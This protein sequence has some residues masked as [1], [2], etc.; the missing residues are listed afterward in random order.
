MSPYLQAAIRD[1]DVIFGLNIRFGESTTEGWRLMEVP[2]PAQTL[3]HSHISDLEL[4]KIYQADAP[5]H[6]GPNTLMADLAAREP[7]G[8]WQDWRQK[9]RDGFTGMRA[10][11]TQTGAVN[12]VEICAYLRDHLAP[13]CIVTNGAG[14]FAIW[15]SKFLNFGGDRRLLAPQSGAMGAGLPAAIAAKTVDSTRQVVCFAGD[16][17]IQMQLAELGTAAQEG[18]QPIILLLNNGMYGTIRA[19]QEKHYPNRISATRIV[20]PDFVAIARAYGFHSERISATAEFPD[21]FQRAVKSTGGA[22]LEIMIDPED[23][24][25]FATLEKIRGTGRVHKAT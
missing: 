23:I 5:V 16:G 20:N 14:N 4:G 18:L 8:N 19:H 21:A 7:I 17:D 6:A 3:I 11:A 1:A 24:S 9:T 22:L 15:P 25:P 13:D 10:R 2:N 12:M